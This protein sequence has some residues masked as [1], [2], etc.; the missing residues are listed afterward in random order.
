MGA[1]GFLKAVAVLALLWTGARAG[2]STVVEPIARLSLEGGFDSNPLH[3]GSGTAET[4]RVS[5]DVGLRARDHLWDVDLTYGGDWV[6]FRDRG[7]GIWNHRAVLRLEATPTRRLELSG[8]A[9]VDYARDVL[10]LAAMGI[11]RTTRDAALFTSARARGEYRLARRFDLAGTLA[12]RIVVFDDGTGGAMHAP[13]VELLARL[14][15][16]LRV[17]VAGGVSFFQRFEEDYEEIAFAHSLR[18]RAELRAS[19]TMTINLL[20]GPALW[21]GPDAS[22]VVPEAS[23]ELL[24][25]TRSSDLRVEMAH[26]L[27]IGSTARPALLDSAEMGAAWRFGHRAVLRGDAGL[28][29][30]G[31]APSGDDATLGYATSGEAGLLFRRGLQLSLRV[32]R[33]ARLDE[34]LPELNRTVVA[35]R[36]GWELE[37]R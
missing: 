22:A 36:F 5:P 14:E 32:S 8:R 19:R 31:L 34:S 13:G 7:Q 2:A 6:V 28:W 20:A 12:E 35:L 29:H 16:P 1:R 26:G 24:R 30:S 4:G 18:G 37:T 15:R 11:F 25:S 23:V 33:Y 21:M 9:R 17:G 3:D 27:G 10:G